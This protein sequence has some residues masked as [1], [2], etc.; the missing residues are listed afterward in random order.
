MHGMGSFGPALEESS[1]LKWHEIGHAVDA[2]SLASSK[3]H[4]EKFADFV[5]K[6]DSMTDADGNTI[7]DNTLVLYANEDCTGGHFLM[8]MPIVVAGGKGRI[9]TDQVIDY[10]NLN[11]PVRSSQFLDS[12]GH[13]RSMFYGRPYN[14]LLVTVLKAFGLTEADYKRYPDQDGYG[15]YTGGHGASHYTRFVSTSAERNATLPGLWTG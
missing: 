12:S 15:R 8:D 10:R 7:L 1:D 2:R 4:A 9:R 3:W 5:K 11:D 6:L 13:G 14:N